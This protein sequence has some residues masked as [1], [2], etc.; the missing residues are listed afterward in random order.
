MSAFQR[1]SHDDFSEKYIGNILSSKDTMLAVFV[2]DSLGI[3]D[4]RPGGNTFRYLK[5]AFKRNTVLMLPSVEDPVGAIGIVKGIRALE[6]SVPHASAAKAKLEKLK[7][8]TNV[9][10]IELPGTSLLASRDDALRNADDV[11][12]A[13]MDTLTAGGKS[14]IGVYTG[15]KS[16]F[17][18]EASGTRSRRHLLQAAAEPSN[19]SDASGVLM[20][21][22]RCLLL[23]GHSVAVSFIAKDNKTD[24]HVM[25]TYNT[26]LSPA[27]TPQCS[28][29]GA[30]I[31]I[32]FPDEGGARDFSLKMKFSK[33]GFDGYTLKEVMGSLDTDKDLEMRIEDT[34]WP[35]GFSYACRRTVFKQFNSTKEPHL[36]VTIHRFQAELFPNRTSSSFAEGY[37]CAGFFTM[38]VWMGFVVVLLYLVI[39][40]TGIFFLYDI[41]TNDRFDDPK[42]KTITV[43]ATD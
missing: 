42:G 25:V 36:R 3:E 5:S 34:W 37:D 4:L 2:Q 6:I 24:T 32:T 18:Q 14:V 11:M 26:T 7:G 33:V 21:R 12:E 13:V 31:T 10:V 43:T 17:G 9:V 38:P 20:V 40:G 27:P 15:R 8:H 23:Y 39:L 35:S 41:R 29:T 16:S 22:S 28:D 19:A 30:N 1:V